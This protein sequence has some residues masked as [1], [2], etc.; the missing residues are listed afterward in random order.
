[1]NHV[2][3]W[4]REIRDNPLPIFGVAVTIIGGVLMLCGYW[5]MYKDSRRRIN[6]EFEIILR[7]I[8]EKYE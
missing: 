5:H 8:D 2:I 3:T 7:R 4:I 1:M 6:R